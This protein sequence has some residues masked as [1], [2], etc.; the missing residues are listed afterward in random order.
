M[1]EPKSDHHWWKSVLDPIEAV[2]TQELARTEEAEEAQNPGPVSTQTGASERERLQRMAKRQREL[3]QRL[4]AAEQQA[5]EM[6]QEL[7]HALGNIEQWQQSLEA[8]REKH[9]KKE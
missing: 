1:S 4:A 6:D 2:L 5:R 9:E 8:F 7:T 3:N